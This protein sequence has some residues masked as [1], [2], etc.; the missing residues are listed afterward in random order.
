VTGSTTLSVTEDTANTK[1]YSVGHGPQGIAID[2]TGNAWVTNTSS[3]NV[4]KLSPSGTVLGTYAVGSWP[5]AV[6]IDGSGNVWVANL[7][8]NNVTKLSSS[9]SVLGTYEVGTD[10][11]GIAIDG[12]GNIWVANGNL[13]Y[14]SSNNVTKL[15]SS[16]SVLGTYEVGASCSGGIAIDGS[17][18]VWVTNGNIPGTSSSANGTNVTKLGSSGAILGTYPVGTNPIGIAIDGS[19][20][21]WVANYGN[22]N[23]SDNSGSVTKLSPSGDVLGTFLQNGS[24]SPAGSI[25]PEGAS[26]AIDGANNV[27]VVDGDSFVIELS[28]SGA[29]IYYNYVDDALNAYPFGIAIDS[30]GNI[31]FANNGGGSGAGF[32]GPAGNVSELIDV[33]SPVNTPLFLQPK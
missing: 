32:I 14:G 15:S 26:I 2:G 19:G 23:T 20:N 27:W 33:A 18:N 16:G 22:D 31:W 4:T 25:S 10:P 29:L 3:N 8:S 5:A 6:A 17:G 11:G 28:P 7:L 1:T 12:L 30:S 24:S 9:G 13:F 21:V